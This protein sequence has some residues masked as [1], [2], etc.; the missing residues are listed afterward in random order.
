VQKGHILGVFHAHRNC[1]YRHVPPRETFDR[2]FFVNIVL[3]SLKKKLAQ[4]P[5]PNPEKD[6]ALHLD[7]ARP[8]LADHEIQAYN[9][10]RL[11]HPAYSPDLTAA[12]FWLFGYSKI[13]LEGNSF[14]MTEE[15]QR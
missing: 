7:N 10:T 4:I 6:H 12:N 13:I 14:E 5:D 15:L 2:S 8:H 9:I 3:D 11:S 1:R